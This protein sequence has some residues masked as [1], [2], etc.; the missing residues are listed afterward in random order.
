M[1]IFL[2]LASNDEISVL[3]IPVLLCGMQTTFGSVVY[4]YM[5]LYK[6]YKRQ[7]CVMALPENVCICVDLNPVEKK[8]H[9]MFFKENDVS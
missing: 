8:I 6:L 7:N 9:Q 4:K 3:I 5:Q 1:N 2:H